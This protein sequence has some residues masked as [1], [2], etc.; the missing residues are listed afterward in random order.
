MCRPTGFPISRERQNWINA[1]L[2]PL[3]YGRATRVARGWH[4][5]SPPET[6]QAVAAGRSPDVV[7]VRRE[8]SE[9]KSRGE[10]ALRWGR[11][12]VLGWV[13]AVAASP[14]AA[15]C[16]DVAPAVAVIARAWEARE[17][18]RGLPADLGMAEAVCI[19]DRLVKRLEA[20]FGRIIGYK[21]GLTSQALQE[22]FG[23]ASPVRGA[24][25]EQTV[26]PDN[27]E[28]AARFGARPVVEA[29]LLVEVRDEAINSAAT[30]L[31]VLKALAAVIPFIELPDLGIAEGE[32]ITAP[33]IV[34]IN[35]G[36][37]AGV[38]GRPVPVEAS[39]AFGERLAAM[40]VVMRDETG[41]E[42]ASAPGSAILGH[43]LN[44]VRWLVEDLRR[45]GVRL[46]KGDLLSLG[47]FSPLAPPRP[48]GGYTVRYL[49]LPG[50]PEVSVRF[51]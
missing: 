47:S 38:R 46:K 28:V 15:S 10:R 49:G 21:A 45:A 41:K 17:P 43:P 9:A 18:V 12:A 4:M 22:R 32:K 2:C 16:P 20:R 3:E 37:R 44:A 26:L 23:H 42:V 27:A 5:T 39:D 31:D 6:L 1:S 25:F 36:A 11:S 14:A 35:V 50:D 34:A 24:L 33:K 48:G 19:R 13:F 8:R 7:S 40:R 29:D 30:Q 51:K